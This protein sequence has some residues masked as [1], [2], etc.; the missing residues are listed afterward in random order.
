MSSDLTGTVAITDYGWYRFLRDLD[1]LDGPEEVNFWKPSAA[2]AFRAAPAA[3]FLFKLGKPHGAICGFSL[4]VRYSKLPDW[5]AW[6]CFGTANGCGS[7]ADMRDRLRTIRVRMSFKGPL[8]DPV[9]GC[10][11]LVSPVF[12]PE[13]RLVKPPA[14]WP[15]H[16][17]GHKKYDLTRG[18]G[19]R[20]WQQCLGIAAELRDSGM[21]REV[22]AGAREVAP[23]FGPPQQVRPRL[24]QGTFRIEVME[25]YARGCVVTGEHSLPALEAAHIRPHAGSGPHEVSNG[26]LLV[27]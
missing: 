15:P 24:G 27:A 16:L 3:P 11:L 13:D 12:F 4:F 1:G 6:D 21:L 2:R 20:V 25:A 19:A 14:D 8:D 17:Q 10:V 9:I 7:L 26:L 5:L 22:A 18:E 23:R